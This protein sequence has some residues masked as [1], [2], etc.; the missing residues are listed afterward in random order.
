MHS[1]YIQKQPSFI[2]LGGIFMNFEIS[3][4]KLVEKANENENYTLLRVELERKISRYEYSYE[5]GDYTFMH[6]V[7]NHST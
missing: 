3:T 6:M 2:P 7:L 5:L 4:W 1:F